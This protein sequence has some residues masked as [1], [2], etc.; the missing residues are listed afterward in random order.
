[1]DLI[2]LRKENELVDLFCSM[3]EVPSPSLKE[4]KIIDWVCNYCKENNLNWN[5]ISS[6]FYTFKPKNEQEEKVKQL[7][8]QAIKS[9]DKVDTNERA[10]VAYERNEDGKI[11]YYVYKIYS[12]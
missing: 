6:M 1:M 8:Q 3:A 7:F 12:L 5:S 11:I 4:D 9:T 10:E 2:D